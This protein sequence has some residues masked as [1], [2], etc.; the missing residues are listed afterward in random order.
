MTIGIVIFH[1]KYSFIESLTNMNGYN[2][3]QLFDLFG[4]IAVGYFFTVSG[5]L[6]FY[7]VN[8]YIDIFNKIKRRITSLVVPFLLWN[9]IAMIWSI[10]VLKKD[11]VILEI[12][13]GFTYEPY[14][15]VLWYVFVLI[16][17]MLLSPILYLWLSRNDKSILFIGSILIIVS[18]LG[19]Y[20][21]S[22]DNSL[23]W[24]TRILGYLP[25]YI[26]GAIFGSLK[27][28]KVL[29]ISRR[30]R[31]IAIMYLILAILSFYRITFFENYVILSRM[32]LVFLPISIW[33]IIPDDSVK[34]SPLWCM[35]TSF[36]IFTTHQIF[37]IPIFD[38]IERM[39][40]IL[41]F[42]SISVGLLYFVVKVVALIGIVTICCYFLK[43]KNNRLYQILSGGRGY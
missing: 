19:Y 16:I 33:F 17:L 6:F 31:I 26:I 25:N 42:N 7:N 24:F 37:L 11:L 38:K 29:N 18:L 34:N 32:V 21:T 27:Y 14:N 23:W 12:I 22:F 30:M 10:I 4:Y 9:L 1:W 35:K 8:N 15:G 28:V 3:Y 20:W 36:F 5:F 40:G 2:F 13:K 43:K 39:V 41:R